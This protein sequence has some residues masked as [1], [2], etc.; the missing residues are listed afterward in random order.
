MIGYTL[1]WVVCVPGVIQSA[2]GPVSYRFLLDSSL[3]DGRVVRRDVDQIRQ[4]HST[5]L[6]VKP[7]AAIL[8]QQEDALEPNSPPPA[9]T[10]P[11]SSPPRKH[12]EGPSGEDTPGS[13]PTP[14]LETQDTATQQRLS[15][16]TSPAAAG[17][18]VSTTEAP[19]WS[20]R[21]RHAPD[22]WGY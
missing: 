1:M 4:R 13:S 7:P 15:P 17:A 9:E 8:P 5:L 11:A 18:A 16:L 2:T 10:V 6:E 21:I 19:R 12:L 14:P 3:E 20:G 22:R